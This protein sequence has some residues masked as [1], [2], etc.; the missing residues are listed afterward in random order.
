MRAQLRGK[1]SA[2]V[3]TGIAFAL[4]FATF[5]AA[6]R[7]A[8]A[9]VPLEAALCQVVYPLD[10]FP[11]AQNYHYTFFGNAFFINEDGYL[12]TASHVVSAFREGGK[13]HII[14]G[15]P[16]EPRRLLEAQIVAADWDHDVAVLRATPNPFP[17]DGKVAYL[18]LSVAT[19]PKGESV[20]SAS[21]R[22]PE[23]ENVSSADVPVEDYSKGEVLDYRFHKE[24]GLPDSEVLIVSQEVAPG[25]SGSPLVAA[26]SQGVVGIIVGRWL[27]PVVLPSS[28]ATRNRL[29]LS[30]GA[31]LRIHYAIS[32]LEKNHIAWHAAKPAAAEAVPAREPARAQDSGV[33]PPEAV[34]VV[35]V[36]YPPQA[37][38][39]GDVL[40]DALI[41]SDGKPA[42]IRVVSGDGPFLDP[43]LSAVRTWTFKPAEQDGRAVEARI[44]IV[45]Q[46]AQSFLPKEVSRERKHDDVLSDTENRGPLPIVTLEPNYPVNSV[47]EGSV[48]LYGLVDPDGHLN[49]LSTLFG[50][51]SLTTPTADAVHRWQF[52]P[53]KQGGAANE[54]AVIVV[55]TFRRPTL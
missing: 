39:G 13:P 1:L 3:F 55:E 41:D 9:G 22:F 53:G 31:A 8:A 15:S 32:L 38:F 48:G 29:A 12:I 35:G 47:A 49:S 5:E 24:T 18:P 28:A 2:L 10:Q 54:S 44:G 21:L 26:N 17:G 33:V 7:V 36:N 4:S 6:P 43:A 52:A 11:G 14:V 51:G 23:A 40:L 37:L 50:V 34:S 25:Q 27:L 42:D 46:F 16:E 30:P 19:P 20:L 45:F